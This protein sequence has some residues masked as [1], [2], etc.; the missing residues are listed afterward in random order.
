MSY[1]GNDPSW[2]RAFA[3]FW[4]VWH[5]RFHDVGC[6]PRSINA[7][8]LS[9]QPSSPAATAGPHAVAACTSF[10]RS[11]TLDFATERVGTGQIYRPMI[12]AGCLIHNL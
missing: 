10:M 3:R 12:D 11:E 7:W 2:G 9:C 4:T 8:I 6:K 1:S 5:V